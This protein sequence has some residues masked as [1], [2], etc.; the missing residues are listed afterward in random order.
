MGLIVLQQWV[1]SDVAR[2]PVGN[3]DEVAI[4]E[5]QERRDSKLLKPAARHSSYQQVQYNTLVLVRD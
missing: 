4:R 2:R 3:V 1:Y 5:N